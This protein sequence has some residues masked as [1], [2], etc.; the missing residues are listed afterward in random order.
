[1]ENNENTNLTASAVIKTGQGRLVGMY[2]NSTSSGTIRFNDGSSGT[3]SAGAKATQ[4]LTTT[5]VFSNGE[6]V[7][8][9]N[10][11][12]TMVDTLTSVADQ[13]LIGVSAAVSLDNLK[14]AVNAT[15]GAGTTYSNGTI[16][17]TQVTATTNADTTQVFEAISLG[18]AGNS[19]A[20]TG[21]CANAS[22]GAAVLAGGVD[23][24]T[25][26]NNTIT[27]AIGY[28]PLGNTSFARGLYATIANTLNVTL[29][30][31]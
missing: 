30:W 9:G 11:T 15:A 14:S 31:N 29:Y 21:T 3:P 22:F 26:I 18:T 20:T 7:T 24:N 1:M 6:T 5:G 25:T 19:I 28:H 2:V 17:H 4:T 13:V 23:V 8:V 10:R 16:A 27:P 12:Y